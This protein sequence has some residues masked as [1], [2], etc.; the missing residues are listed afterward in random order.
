MPPVSFAIIRA[1]CALAIVVPP[2]KQAV[3]GIRADT[4]L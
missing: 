1:F 4:H 2:Y 3:E